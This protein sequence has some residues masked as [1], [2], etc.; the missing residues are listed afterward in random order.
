ML[1]RLQTAVHVHKAY[2]QG[3]FYGVLSQG[4][5]L[6]RQAAADH[7]WSS[8]SIPVCRQLPGIAMLAATV[9]AVVILPALRLLAAIGMSL[10]VL[11]PWPLYLMATI[12]ARAIPL[13]G[14]ST[15]GSSVPTKPS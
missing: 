8:E 5:A 11:D 2:M 6:C 3:T 12:K 13:L 1:C 7:F 10:S 4:K 15:T 9:L 14:L